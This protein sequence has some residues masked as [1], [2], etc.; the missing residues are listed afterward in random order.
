MKNTAKLLALITITIGAS[1]GVGNASEGSTSS[2][3]KPPDTLCTSVECRQFDFWVG[4]WSL[5]WTNAEGKELAGNNRIQSIL[6]GCVIEENF[7]D[8]V[9]KFQGKSV[10]VFNKGTQQW[11]QT[12]V[13]NNGSYLDFVGEFKDGKMVLARKATRE[14]K[15]FLQR[16]VWYNIAADTL[17][18]NW[19]RSDDNGNTWK[20]LWKIH[21]KR[22]EQ[23]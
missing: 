19:E 3:P 8:P 9:G 18:W 7:E 17:D 23:W 5:K 1:L 11:Q 15:E 10:S 14:G 12:W 22:A 2:N 4:D 6:N 21:Y 16:M 13:D 20:L